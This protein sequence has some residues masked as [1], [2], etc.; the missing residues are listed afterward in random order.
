[1]IERTVLA[2]LMLEG[3]PKVS[4]LSTNYKYESLSFSQGIR[5]ITECL[6]SIE[7]IEIPSNL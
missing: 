5:M 1:M 2:E 7:G 6:E 4:M 3:A